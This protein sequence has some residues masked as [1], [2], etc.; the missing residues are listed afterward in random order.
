MI[1]LD[2]QKFELFE[3]PFEI[4]C[5]EKFNLEKPDIHQGG[6]KNLLSVFFNR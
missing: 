3:I 6:R 5:I 1:S 2:I 4:R